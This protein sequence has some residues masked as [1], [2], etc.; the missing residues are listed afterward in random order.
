M[1][2]TKWKRRYWNLSNWL[3]VRNTRNKYPHVAIIKKLQLFLQGIVGTNKDFE[4]IDQR[5]VA[6]FLRLRV[7]QN[8]ALNFDLMTSKLI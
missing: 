7:L 4:D 6:S 2:T 5:V 8:W 3:A 1:G